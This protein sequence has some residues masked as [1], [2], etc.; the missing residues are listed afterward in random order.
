MAASDLSMPE[1]YPMPES[2]R[3]MKPGSARKT[4]GAQGVYCYVH[5]TVCNGRDEAAIFHPMLGR[6]FD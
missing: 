5:H 3:E 1:Y 4:E 6:E 2:N